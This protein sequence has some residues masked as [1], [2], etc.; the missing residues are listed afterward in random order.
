MRVWVVFGLPN[1]QTTLLAVRNQRFSF[2]LF[3]LL[4]NVDGGPPQGAG[5]GVC[6]T[7]PLRAWQEK[8]KKNHTNPQLTADKNRTTDKA[9]KQ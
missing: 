4:W 6:D 8:K 3:S 2:C 9:T 5:Y 1:L 7:S